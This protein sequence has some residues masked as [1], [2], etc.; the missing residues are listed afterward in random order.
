MTIFDVVLS[1]MLGAMLMTLYTH[2]M[3][4]KKLDELFEGA[5]WTP[6]DGNEELDLDLL[7]E[8]MRRALD[9]EA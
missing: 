5:S 3:K 6:I 7:E 8:Q 9:E 1:F 2:H 4:L